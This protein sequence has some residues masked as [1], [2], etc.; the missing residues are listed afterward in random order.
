[1]LRTDRTPAPRLLP[2]L[3]TA[4]Y[5]SG[6]MAQSQIEEVIVT[7]QKRQEKLQDVP[8]SITA[9]SGA[10]LE[11]RGIEGIANLNALAPNL[12]FRSNNPSDLISTVALRGSV[13]GQPGIWV[14]PAV[15][16]YVDGI[17]V[18]KSQGSV[19]DVVEIERVEVLRGPQGTLFGRN[20]EGGAVN[21]VSR[22]PSGA[23]GGS[24]GLEIG[25]RNHAVE[26]IALDLPRMGIASISIAARKE[27]RDGWAKNTNGA[28]MGARDKEA[29]RVAATLDFTK[30]FRLDY[31]Y[32]K[33]DIDNSPPVTSL[34][35]L[36]G[37]AGSVKDF[38][39]PYAPY[40]GGAA[41]V[42]ALGN[43][44]HDAMMP[45]VRTSRPGKVALN[46]PAGPWERSN[47]EGHALTLNYKL[48]DGNTVKY[49]YSKRNMKHKELQ[50]I[51]GTPLTSIQVFPGFDWGMGMN[52][53]GNTDYDQESHELQWIG[54]AGPLKY[55]LGAYFYTD[56]GIARSN[57]DFSF[58]AEEPL[59]SDYGTK[60]DVKAL[61]GQIDY[62][63]SDRLTATIGMR[64]TEEEKKGWT[65]RYL[66]NGFAGSLKAE[67]I[68]RVDYRRDFSG[69]T[70]MA[71]LAYKLDEA[72]NL[73][74]RV[75]KGW[76]SGGFNSDV[77]ELAAITAYQPQK[78][79]SVE[80]GIKKMFLNNR[81]QINVALFQNKITDQQLTRLV[82]GTTASVLT[83]A[84]KSTYR[85][86]E[87]EGALVP[88]DGWKLQASY[89]YLET[90]FD[91]FMDA[92]INLP[93]RPVI[94]TASN[95]EAPFAP[96]HTFSLN[97][98][99][100]LAKTAWGTLRGILDYSYTA[101]IYNMICNKNIAA[102][103][104]GGSNSC[105]MSQMPAIDMLNARLLLAGIP[106]GG[107]GTA[108]ISLW[109]KN[110]TDEKKQINGI[111][112]S[113][114]RTANWQAP[115]TYGLG[116]NYKW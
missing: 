36:S 76:K 100:R 99:G 56:D 108:D 64:R 69:N 72:T 30:D 66:T 25:N 81:A 62:S 116:F 74:F 18:G 51:D 44:Q 61:F 63:L 31:T 86:I 37:W 39:L 75:A 22:R 5:A 101:K 28:D 91:S 102:P 12:M 94:Q 15:G 27:D 84:G 2:L 58:F 73:Y 89:G 104:A 6:A 1:M 53:D 3:L 49:I 87:L 106:V 21:M 111:D 52:F 96:K 29:F 46:S 13:S 34:Y 19:F 16:M 23:W 83:N 114:I 48:N 109:V 14:D 67:I 112:F 105:P 8:L 90:D 32:D 65:H 10:Q 92:A 17:Y 50:D 11:T 93:G 79:T 20:T 107:P 47:V 9:I 7:A 98:D 115:R 59:R 24:I 85:G 60:T 54:H 97:V 80:A 55:V 103:N 88:V 78:S 38:W 110:L 33:S 43:A 4:A 35:A 113:M 68:P 42:T 26:R 45:Y 41:V 57:Q 95:K 70:P 77:A 82:P 71:A 40:F